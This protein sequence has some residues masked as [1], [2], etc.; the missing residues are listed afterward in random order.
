MSE[1]GPTIETDPDAASVAALA[2]DLRVVVGRLRRRLR[3]QMNPGDLNW[4]QVAVLGRLDRDGPT[5]VTALAQAEGMRTQSMGAN[6]AALEAAGL[7]ART[8]DPADGRQAILALT[9]TCREWVRASRTARE[10][11]LVEA[12]RTHVAPAEQV[13]LAGAIA[14]LKR[15]VDA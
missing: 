4:S 9:P 11:W 12:L 2:T 6:I 5:T 3:E 13:Q 14:V 8:P 1:P 7:V 15:L 10:D